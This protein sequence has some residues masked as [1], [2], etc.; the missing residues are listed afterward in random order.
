MDLID[1]LVA[2]KRNTYAAGKGAVI[3]SRA[4]AKDL[5]YTAGGF[6]YLDSYFGGKRFSGQEIVYKNGAPVWSMNYFGVL[7]PDQ[8]PA[9]FS[10]TLHEALLRVDRQA[11]FRGPDRYDNGS[12]RY[13]CKHS[14]AIDFFQGTELIF[15]ESSEV[16]RLFFHGGKV[17]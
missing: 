13:E 3:P 11:P 17:E 15:H 5:E 10:E 7:M 14:G 1:F 16:Y 8:A 9:G 12:C 6:R 4:G 2:A